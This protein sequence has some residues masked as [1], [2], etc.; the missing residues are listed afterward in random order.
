MWFGLEGKRRR[1]VTFAPCRWVWVLHAVLAM[2]GV[3]QCHS[4]TLSCSPYLCNCSA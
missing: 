4:Q 3:C 2:Q 1:I